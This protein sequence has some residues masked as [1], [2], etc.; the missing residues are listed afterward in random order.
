LPQPN[1]SL[2][3]PATYR[4]ALVD[5]TSQAPYRHAVLTAAMSGLGAPSRVHDVAITPNGSKAVVTTRAGTLVF[6]LTQPV[7][8]TPPHPLPAVVATS[9]DPLNFTNLNY[10]VSD[11]VACTDSR[12]IVIGT[13]HQASPQAVA[14]VIDL[15]TP[16]FPITTIPLGGAGLF[17]PTDVTVTPDGTKALVRSLQ[18]ATNHA[19]RITVINLITGAVL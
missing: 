16:G 15:L 2:S 19:D 9:A 5:L 14:Q 3:D 12:A 17:I 8:Q 7:I 13:D 1:P 4:V 6:D 11:S 10:F 18:V